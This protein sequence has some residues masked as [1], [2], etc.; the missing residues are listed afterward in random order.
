MNTNLY[1]QAKQLTKVTTPDVMLSQAATLWCSDRH[2]LARCNAVKIGSAQKGVK[3]RMIFSMVDIIEKIQ[4]EFP[5]LVINILGEVDFV[6]EYVPDAKT[7]RLWEWCKTFI[8][9][10]IT[11][12]GAAFAIMTFNSD[13]DVPEVFKMLYQ[14]FLGH[15]GQ[16]VYWLEWSYSIGLGLGIIIFYNHLSKKGQEDD[17]TPLEVEMRTYEQT[18]VMTEIKNNERKQAKQ[19]TK[20]S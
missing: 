20:T 15:E 19:S 12:C 14:M 4:Q 1:I 9:I 17:P 13:V 3:K 8:I 10:V 11:F 7:S 6:V 16:S 5:D 18:L 2:V